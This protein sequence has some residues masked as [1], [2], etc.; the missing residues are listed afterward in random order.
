MVQA[1]LP[2]GSGGMFEA[3]SC[4]KDVARRL[5][6]PALHDAVLCACI[7]PCAAR[8]AER[9][10]LGVRHSVHPVACDQQRLQARDGCLMK[11]GQGGYT[12]TRR[13]WQRLGARHT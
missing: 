9:Q 10:E 11:P 1:S 3:R 5:Y 6:T 4:S 12:C 2:Y 8:W 7:E 13:R